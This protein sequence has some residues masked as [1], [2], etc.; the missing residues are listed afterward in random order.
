MQNMKLKTSLFEIEV[1]SDGGEVT[2]LFE[3]S[4]KA[5]ISATEQQQAQPL[6]GP[7]NST[8]PTKGTTKL[9][10]SPQHPQGTINTIVAKLNAK[11]CRELLMAAMV[12]HTLVEGNARVSRADW[13]DCAKESHTW[14]VD[15][16]NQMAL[17]V[18]RLVA[19]GFVVENA[20]D[21][22]SLSTDQV[23]EY[24]QKLSN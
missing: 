14:K 16:S 1:S 12:H 21:V 19:N 3:R 5:A 15:Y 10:S 11:S 4:L 9:D 22:F 13:I 2:D 23:A 8:T 18:K 17:N 7:S 6:D 20:K 24:S